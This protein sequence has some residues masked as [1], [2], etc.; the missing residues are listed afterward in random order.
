MIK[1]VS[2]LAFCGTEFGVVNPELTGSQLMRA[3]R[4]VVCSDLNPSCFYNSCSCVDVR[5]PSLL[6]QF[7]R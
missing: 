5:F 4:L 3:R 6:S 1:P 7:V 2:I